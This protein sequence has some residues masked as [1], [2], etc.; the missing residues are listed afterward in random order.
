MRLSEVLNALHGESGSVQ[1]RVPED[2]L[3]GRSVFGG[4]QAAIAV[5][6][7]RSLIG[8]DAPLRTLQGTFIGP[9]DADVSAQA[10]IL[11]RGRNTLHVE[12]RIVASGE[13]LAVFIGIFGSLR[14]S[15]V[16]QIAMLSTVVEHTEQTFPFIAGVTPNFIQHFDAILTVGALPFAG[17]P[18]AHAR[19]RLSLKDEDA[20]MSESHLLAFADF[21]PPLAMSALRRPAPGSSLTWQVDLLVDDLTPY[22]L[23]GWCV[24]IELLAAGGGYGSQ[25]TAIVAPD[26]TTVAL[27]RQCMAVFG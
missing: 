3:Q 9:V 12:A 26:G 11:R 8:T 25:S 24:D 5:R 14:E 15:V 4:L 2:W 27:G 1:V 18:H 7:M 17:I 10:Q 16:E 23:A 20:A 13:V 6:A 22:A 19:Y 21:A